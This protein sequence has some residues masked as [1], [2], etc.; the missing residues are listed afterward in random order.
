MVK[1][2]W[3]V[4]VSALALAI[5]PAS[6]STSSASQYRLVIE[7]EFDQGYSRNSFKHWI[8]ADRDGCNTRAEVLIEEATKKPKVGKKCSL[9]AGKWISPYDGKSYT[10][11]SKLDIDHLVPLA[12]AWRSGAWKWTSEERE[13]FANDLDEPGAL[14]AVTL[15]LNRSK[16]DKDISQWLPPLFKCQYLESWVNVKMKYGLFADA[17]EAEAIRDVGK[18]CSIAVEFTKSDGDETPPMASPSPKPSTSPSTITVS[19]SP[20][21]SPTSG[22]TTS[23]P[24]PNPTQ[25]RQ[26]SPGAFCSQSEA[27]QIGQNSKGVI[28][29]C[30]VS[31]TENRLRWRI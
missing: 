29:T 12:E 7:P 1:L 21:S 19:P 18:T 6:F 16:G 24:S 20:A 9:T 30:K 31:S 13:R 23:T 5:L 10:N 8:D 3:L 22:S 15:N 28:Y 26:I 14:I 27:G 11:P 25:L 2:R 4:V 17:N